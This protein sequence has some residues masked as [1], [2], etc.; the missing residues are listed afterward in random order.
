MNE[1]PNVTIG[2]FVENPTPFLREFFEKISKLNYPK[3]KISIL[4]HNNVSEKRTASFAN[5]TKQV[6]FFFHLKV[7]FHLELVEKFFVDSKNEYSSIKYIAPEDDS[8]E[9]T[10]FK[11]IFIIEWCVFIVKY[12]IK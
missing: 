8:P 2:L 6:L 10:N 7:K 3:S 11:F 1:W 4:I 12:S 5:K 9:V